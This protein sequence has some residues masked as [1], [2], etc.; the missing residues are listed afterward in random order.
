MA[1]LNRTYKA[2]EQL[3]NNQ[4]LILFRFDYVGQ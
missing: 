1:A 2:Y 4:I 3:T